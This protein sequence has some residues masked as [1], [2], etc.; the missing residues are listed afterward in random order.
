M[1]FASFHAFVTGD[2]GTIYSDSWLQ[3]FVPFW[4]HMPLLLFFRLG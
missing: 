4:C 2:V 1:Q 3:L